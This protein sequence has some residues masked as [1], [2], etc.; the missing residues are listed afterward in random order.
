M[1]KDTILAVLAIALA[2]CIVAWVTYACCLLVGVE[3]HADELN[4]VSYGLVRIDGCQ[5]GIAHKGDCDSPVHGGHGVADTSW[6]E[7]DRLFAPTSSSEEVTKDLAAREQI[8]INWH[9]HP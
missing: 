4:P 6:S 8:E 9:S 7:A 5:Y 1:K 2:S 3:S